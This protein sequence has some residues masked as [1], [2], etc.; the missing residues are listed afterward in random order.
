M[1]PYLFRS[2]NSFGMNVNK[3]PFDDIRVRKAMQM[4]LDLETIYATYL[5]V[6]ESTR[7]Q[8]GRLPMIRKGGAPHLKSGPKRSRKAIPV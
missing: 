5:R 7:P 1:D 3:P 8:V 2:N 6:M 4:A